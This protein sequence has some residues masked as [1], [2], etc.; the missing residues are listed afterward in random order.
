MPQ[1]SAAKGP[2]WPLSKI[3]A[4]PSLRCAFCKRVQPMSREHVWPEWLLSIIKNAQRAKIL[5]AGLRRNEGMPETF[6]FRRERKGLRVREVCVECN[7]GWLSDIEQDAQVLGRLAVGS[8]STLTEEDQ[9]GIAVWAWKT[10]LVIS[11][12]SPDDVVPENLYQALNASKSPPRH[13][14]AAIVLAAFDPPEIAV[15]GRVQRR[16]DFALPGL[17]RVLAF[18]ASFI[19]GHA[20][21]QVIGHEVTGYSDNEPRLPPSMRGAAHLLWPPR[22]KEVR[23]PPLYRLDAAGVRNLSISISGM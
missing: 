13:G 14:A 7:S 20:V 17:G 11:L 9:R 12:A 22:R 23:W 10:A 4:M 15:W 3:L 16:H 2:K 5:E 18:G 8:P 1:V 6:G 21:L 19:V